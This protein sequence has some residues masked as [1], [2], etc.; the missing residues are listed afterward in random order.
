MSY[1]IVKPATREEWLQE[2]THG[3]GSSE[4]G[5]LMG[6]SPFDTPL[7]LWY[8]KKGLTE[9]KSETMAM[10]LGHYLEP[11]IAQ[12]FSDTT[13]CVIDPY[14]EGD[15]LAVDNDRPFLRVSPDRLYWDKGQERISLNWKILEVKSTAMEVNPENIPLSWYC[16]VQYQMGVMGIREAT[17][18]WFSYSHPAKMGYRTIPFNPAFYDR[19]TQRISHFWLVNIMQDVPP[20]PVTSEDYTIRYPHSNETSFE[21]SREDV[22]LCHEYLVLKQSIKEDEELLRQKET[23]LKARLKDVAALTA[24]DSKGRRK[25]IVTFRTTSENTFNETKFAKDYPDI[26]RQMTSTTLDRKKLNEQHPELYSYYT[27]TTKGPRRFTVR[28]IVLDINPE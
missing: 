24:R 23:Q 13:G 4:A 15:W 26:Y 16:Q 27:E 18:V 2:R 7:T 20:E 11:A 19:L 17:I 6:V 21:A 28:K 12:W 8:R 25:E 10:L 5:V 22:L 1:T 14:S 9:P 3:I